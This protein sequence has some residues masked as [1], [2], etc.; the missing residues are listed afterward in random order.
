[1]HGLLSIFLCHG[2]IDDCNSEM[3]QHKTMQVM[4]YYFGVHLYNLFPTFRKL[5]SSNAWWKQLLGLMYRP[6]W[7]IIVFQ[8]K[9][10]SLNIAILEKIQ[11]HQSK[12]CERIVWRHEGHM[13]IKGCM[14]VI[15]ETWRIQKEALSFLAREK[16]VFNA[17]EYFGWLESIGAK[18]TI[19][20][21]EYSI[22]MI[23]K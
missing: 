18:P 4:V 23:T 9:I 2:S 13:C 20:Q 10:T 22:T 5:E 19:H 14:S 8:T 3:V 16:E 1:M 21:R 12:V 11:V 7:V 17:L 15:F 6:F